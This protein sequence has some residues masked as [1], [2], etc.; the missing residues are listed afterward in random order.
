MSRKLMPALT[1]HCPG[2]L[3]LS[4]STIFGHYKRLGGHGL[5]YVT[6]DECVE[7]E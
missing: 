6:I 4:P 2:L 7:S 5:N 1:Y 3:D